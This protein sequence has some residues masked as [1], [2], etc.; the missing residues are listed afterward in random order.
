MASPLL[1]VPHSP[2]RVSF[3]EAAR[4]TPGP[5]LETLASSPGSASAPLLT[6]ASSSAGDGGAC[7]A[8]AL[9]LIHI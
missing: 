9:S 1:A 7:T 3:D 5:P 6:T 2:A 4:V 8:S